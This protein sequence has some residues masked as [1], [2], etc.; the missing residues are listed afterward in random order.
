MSMK[1]SVRNYRGVASADF[2][3]E[4]ITFIG[5][6]NHQ[7][8]TSLCQAIAA[9]KTG[10]IIPFE[11]LPKSKIKNIV[12]DGAK[13]GSCK[14]TEGES[15][16]IITWPNGLYNMA[17]PA[18][19]HITKMAAG[20]VSVLDYKKKPD[21]I[22][23]VA[24]YIKADPTLED[25]EREL[26]AAD[27]PK[28]AAKQ[29]IERVKVSGYLTMHAKAKERGAQLKG[30]WEFIT[31]QR[32]GSTK[33]EGWQPAA[34]FPELEKAD[35]AALQENIDQLKRD[36]EA[37][38][39][40]AAVSGKVIEDLKNQAGAESAYLKD[41]KQIES[42]LSIA[43]N[44]ENEF[45]RKHI[46]LSS[47][48][49]EH[50]CP[51]CGGLLQIKNGKLVV[52]EEMEKSEIDNRTIELKQA[53][54]A[55]ETARADKRNLLQRQAATRQKLQESQDA[56]AELKKIDKS[57]GG[58]KWANR[59]DELR[60]KVSKAEADLKAVNDK[61]QADGIAGAIKAN[62][63]IQEILGPDGLR[64]TKFNEALAPFNQMLSDFCQAAAWATVRMDTNYD[65]YLNDRP[66]VLCSASEQF[67]ARAVLQLAFAKIEGAPLILIDG[68]DI[69]VGKE[70]NGLIAAILKA[71]VPSIIFMSMPDPSKMPPMEKVGGQA[72]W[73]E[74]GEVY[75]NK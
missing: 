8:K 61:R 21:L 6:R 14:I 40:A 7:G 58:E 46:L 64:K 19:K 25:L 30:Q 16:A 44:R 75:A 23:V 18:A 48:P 50:A 11:E 57:K 2:D 51:H 43:M 70:R 39:A 12:R 17:G 56:A 26:K 22:N 36:L 73:I 54:D 62:K 67:Q 5:G 35:P 15:T 42:D 68:A 3:H 66:I 53:G 9:V 55:L 45:Q 1:I 20:L 49:E 10:E 28:D 37:G 63:S 71:Q 38:I 24:D 59:V 74:K 65:F 27:I 69:I 72:Y 47:M 41:L 60:A 31:G 34:W 32:Y 13:S 52:Y 29:L 4:K 33:I